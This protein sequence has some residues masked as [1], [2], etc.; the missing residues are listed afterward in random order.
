[1]WP[2]ETGLTGAVLALSW[3]CPKCSRRVRLTP[4]LASLE[5]VLWCRSACPETEGLLQSLSRSMADGDVSGSVRVMT[6][7]PGWRAL[8]VPSTRLQDLRLLRARGATT[9]RLSP[10]GGAKRRS[11]S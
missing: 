5:R 3:T 9:E 2:A 7:M 8:V 6:S 10:P 11:R 1:M 4:S